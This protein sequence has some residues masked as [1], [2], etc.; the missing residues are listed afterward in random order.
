MTKEET[1]SSRGGS[2]AGCKNFITNGDFSDNAFVDVDNCYDGIKDGIVNGWTC[3]FGTADLMGPDNVCSLVAYTASCLDSPFPVRM[4]VGSGGYTEA[5]MTEVSL[6][7]G[8]EISYSMCLDAAEDVVDL[9]VVGTTGF[10]GSC[11]TNS[12]PPAFSANEYIYTAPA[13][14]CDAADQSISF[15]FELQSPI[16]QIILYGT[17]DIEVDNIVL[18]CHNDDVLGITKTLLSNCQYEFRPDVVGQLTIAQVYWDFGDGTTATGL[19]ST[20]MFTQGVHYVTM[21]VVDGFG[22]CTTKTTP[23]ICGIDCTSHICHEDAMNYYKCTAGF[24]IVDP[25]TGIDDDLYFDELCYSV[26]FDCIV[27]QM[28]QALNYAGYTGTF[29]FSSDPKGNIQCTKAGIGNT[30]GVFVYGNITVVNLFGVKAG[31]NGQITCDDT[32]DPS[33][34]PIGDYIDGGPFSNCD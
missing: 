21:T 9:V 25:V 8:P 31:W 7:F 4:L 18:N 34:F 27:D 12:G 5:I 15:D 10:V 30:L 33:S 3:A 2:H 14:A 20:H 22:C 11:T 32:L 23:I 28:N 17:S 19:S 24:T 26:D 16:T 6:P 29:V 1:I 13:P